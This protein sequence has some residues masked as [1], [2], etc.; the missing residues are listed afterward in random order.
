[1]KGS[2]LALSTCLILIPVPMA[3][4][5]F[6]VAFQTNP[7]HHEHTILGPRVSLPSRNATNS[8]WLDLSPKDSPLADVGSTGP[9]TQD[10]DVCVIGSGI[11]GVGVAWHL[12]KDFQENLEGGAK[13]KVVLLEARQF[14][15]E[16]FTIIRGTI[17]IPFI[18]VQ[19]LLVFYSASLSNL[20]IYYAHI[21]N[22]R[23][24]RWPSSSRPLLSLYLPRE[25]LWDG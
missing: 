16:Y 6:Q 1:M 25:N 22:A 18:Q 17:L 8:F 4:V 3:A 19:E 11:T 21:T 9:L 14:C 24:K 10:A 12:A 23:T 13:M 20:S 7:D 2:L 15:K 5:D